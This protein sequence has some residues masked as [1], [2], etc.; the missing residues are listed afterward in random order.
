MQTE[1]FRSGA[2]EQLLKVNQVKMEHAY[3]SKFKD[4]SIECLYYQ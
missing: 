2:F 1:D 3:L 4:K